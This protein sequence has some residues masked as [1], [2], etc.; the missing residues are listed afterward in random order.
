MP[1]WIIVCTLVATVAYAAPPPQTLPQFP[2]RD[3]K[4]KLSTAFADIDAPIRGVCQE[5]ARSW[6]RV[7]HRH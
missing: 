7:G 4:A 1:K 3:R 6:S 2:D 5:R